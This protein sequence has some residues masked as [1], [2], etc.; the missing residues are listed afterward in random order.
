MLQP[1]L[2]STLS[3]PP[4]LF[5][6]AT[7]LYSC[8]TSGEKKKE[9]SQKT[10]PKCYSISLS[11]LFWFPFSSFKKRVRFL[12]VSGPFPL[13]LCVM[14]WVLSGFMYIWMKALQMTCLKKKD[15]Y[16][17]KILLF[18]STVALLTF[19]P[20]TALP[21]TSSSRES[22]WSASRHCPLSLPLSGERLI[23]DNVHVSSI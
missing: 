6:V 14:F 21:H 16:E 18:K 13:G 12:S 10:T 22:D 1:L 9:Q 4:C 3:I 8:S 19:A 2:W 15:E 11:L 7:G 20:S 23:L 17:K 5:L